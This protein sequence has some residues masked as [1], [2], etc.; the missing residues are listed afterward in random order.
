MSG[1]EL[2]H[3]FLHFALTFGVDG[4]EVAGEGQCVAAGFVAGEQED[5][6]LTYN[7]ILRY[8][9]FL[10]TPGWQLVW[11][12]MVVLIGGRR[13]CLLVA[14]IGLIFVVRRVR[15]LQRSTLIAASC[16]QHQLKE[17]STP[18]QADEL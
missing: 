9:L 3:L 10:S 6:S 17:V 18:L 14:V 2:I 7:L 12:K 8:H 16:I 4:Q 1:E 15:V 13:L 5:K 11:M